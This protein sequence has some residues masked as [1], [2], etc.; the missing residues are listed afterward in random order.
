MKNVIYCLVLIGIIFLAVDAVPGN[1]NGKG[2]NKCPEECNMVLG[3]FGLEIP[4]HVGISQGYFCKEGIKLCVDQVFTSTV[5]YGKVMTGEYDMILASVDNTIAR[6]I[7]FD[8]PEPFSVIA[9]T[10]GGSR[11]ALLGNK[12]YSSVADLASNPNVVYAADHPTTGL[13][14]Y[15]YDMMRESGVDLSGASNISQLD[16]DERLAVVN[17]GTADICIQAN[18]WSTAEYYA[19]LYPN[20]THLAYVSDFFWPL[21]GTAISIRNDTLDNPEK[22]NLFVKFFKALIKAYDYTVKKANKNKVINILVNNEGMDRSIAARYYTDMVDTIPDLTGIN[23][24]MVPFKRG[25]YNVARVRFDTGFGPAPALIDYSDGPGKFID[26]RPLNQALLETKHIS[27]TE[28]YESG[29]FSCV[30]N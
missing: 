29:S 9:G 23:P 20:V 7:V 30:V 18:K 22:Y 26:L 11:N 2:K 14:L 28:M 17:N 16:N 6:R 4:F 10:N 19:P 25:I 21:Q 24:Y 3:A 5:G 13:V 8:P 15:A 27:A 1:G 12:R